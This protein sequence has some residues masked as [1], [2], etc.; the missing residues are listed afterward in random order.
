MN[1]TANLVRTVGYFRPDLQLSPQK[2]LPLKIY[3]RSIKPAVIS[4]LLT[5]LRVRR[6]LH[7]ALGQVGQDNANSTAGTWRPECIHLPE[8]RFR[9]VEPGLVHQAGHTPWRNLRRLHSNMPRDNIHRIAALMR[10]RIRQAGKQRK[11][12]KKAQGKHQWRKASVYRPEVPS[13][14]TCTLTVPWIPAAIL[15]V[16]E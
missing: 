3:Y 5:P 6:A 8:T 7:H 16:A 14:I 2:C 13:G 9:C 10:A 11:Q 12:Q 15:M 4:A 1:C